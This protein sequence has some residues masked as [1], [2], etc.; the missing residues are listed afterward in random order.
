MSVFLDFELP[1]RLIAQEPCEP[2]D[3]A[4]LLVARR[5]DRSLAHWRFRDLPELL[6]PNDLLVL[7][8]TR[9]IPARLLGKRARTGGKWE[10]LFL[11]SG[12]E[13]T[14]EIIFQAR[15]RLQP[16]EII[17]VEPGPLELTLIS[18]FED[19]R[20][21]V[22]PNDSRGAA[23]VLEQFGHVPLP[24][25]VRQG[26]AGPSDR[27]RYQTVYAQEKGSAAA[28]T[29]GLHFSPELFERLKMRGIAWTFITLHVGLGTFRPL[30]EGDFTGHVL[31]EEWGCL[32]ESAAEAIHACR[33]RG[34]RV[35][36][37]GTTS[38]RVL[39][40]AGQ[41]MPLSP[42]R[43]ETRL[44]IRPPH[45]FNLVDGL[46]TNF[47]WPRTSLLLLVNAFAGEELTA[48]IYQSAL[49]QEYRFF[50]YGDATL[51]L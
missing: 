34:G 39:E 45:A 25:Y 14:W 32:D 46:I 42:W 29:A 31:H 8:D 22:R 40:T 2:R 35:L 24:P 5:Q 47:H 10:G 21:L 17:A 33:R 43:G 28:P 13:G 15:G 27:D 20:W 12:H 49:A 18:R 50:S 11:R 16:D 4:R 19:G 48:S 23:A 41:A 38:A 3:N 36:A 6:D 37:V 1:P 51:I 44:F 30:P 7:N 26:A 9:V